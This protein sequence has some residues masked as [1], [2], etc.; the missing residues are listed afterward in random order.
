[1]TS[2]LAALTFALAAFT[3]TASANAVVATDGGE[4]GKPALRRVDGRIGMLLGGADVGDADGFSVG[5]TAGM[6]YRI[7]DVTLRGVFAY[8]K[9]GDGGD[10]LMSRKKRATRIGGVARYSFLNSGN[11]DEKDVGAD[12]WGEVGVGLEHVA[13]R[14]GGVLDRPSGEIAMG[15]ELD[16]KG[17]RDERD[18]RRH[19]G[20]FMAFRSL[21]A[22][23]PELEGPAVCG[24][25]CTRAT[26][27]SRIDVSMFFEFGL[28]WG[29]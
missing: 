17:D 29:R 16:S 10:E 26:K 3:G 15:F 5:L 7:G 4:L 1:M 13:W 6:G 14:P 19:V 21:V 20:Y 12:F 23:G 8:Y 2:R 24:G 9:V 25:P 11:H 18:R 28:H 27:P 22:Q